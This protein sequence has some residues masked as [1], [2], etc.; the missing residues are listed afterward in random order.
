MTVVRGEDDEIVGIDIC[1]CTPKTY[2]FTFDFNQPCP[3]FFEKI[4]DAIDLIHCWTTD[5]HDRNDPELTDMVPV[6]IQRIDIY[7]R[8]KKSRAISQYHIA[9]PFYDGDSFQFNSATIADN[10]EDSET[11][12]VL[13]VN[14]IPEDI[15]GTIRGVNQFNQ[16]IETHFLIEFTNDCNAYPVLP[17]EGQALGWGRLVSVHFHMFLLI[18]L[19]QPIFFFFRQLPVKSHKIKSFYSSCCIFFFHPYISHR[20]D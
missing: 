17:K 10:E 9:G 18:F 11:T 8:N 15:S 3:R 20:L 7:E 6:L 4:G 16:G 12:M 13:K 1:S 14:D 5:L 19:V 2:E